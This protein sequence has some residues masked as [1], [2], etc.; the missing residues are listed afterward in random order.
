MTSDDAIALIPARGGSKGLPGKNVMELNGVPLIARAIKAAQ[1]SASITETYVTTDDSQIAEVSEKA[2]AKIIYRPPELATDTATSESALLHSLL[3]LKKRGAPHSKYTVFIQCTSPFIISEDVDG[4]VELLRN[5]ADSAFTAYP[6][7]HFLWNETSNGAVGINHD[8]SIRL[9][10]QDM[11][12]QWA[13]AGSVY[14]FNTRGFELHKHRFFGDVRIFPIPNDRA[15]EIDSRSDFEI[16]GTL[17]EV[18][19]W[20]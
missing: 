5:G 11:E 14:G 7:H 16:A 2:G 17:M 1:S 4:V 12:T 13:E 19:G 10:R 18:M 20:D 9:R 8:K 3:E 6:F 15:I